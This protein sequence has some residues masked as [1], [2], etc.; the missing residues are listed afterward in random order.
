[1]AGGEAACLGAAGQAGTEGQEHEG[2]VGDKEDLINDAG[3]DRQLVEI[4][5]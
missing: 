2:F 1:M 3:L 5:E 4:Y